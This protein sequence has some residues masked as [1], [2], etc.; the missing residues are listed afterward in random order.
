MYNGIFWSL[1]QHFT[2]ITRVS[3][4]LTR[5]KTIVHRESMDSLTNILTTGLITSETDKLCPKTFDLNRPH[6]LTV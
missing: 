1:I 6:N 5:P 2:A 3:G 4:G